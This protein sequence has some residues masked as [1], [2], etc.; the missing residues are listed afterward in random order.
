MVRT[1]EFYKRNYEMEFYEVDEALRVLADLENGIVIENDVRN[2]GSNGLKLCL[3]E[4]KYELFKKLVKPFTFQN[5]NKKNYKYLLDAFS[6]GMVEFI[7]SCPGSIMEQMGRMNVSERYKSELEKREYVPFS[8]VEAA[9]EAIVLYPSLRKE[10][11]DAVYSVNLEKVMKIK[12]K[13]VLARQISGMGHPI[14][15]SRDVI[16]YSELPVLCSALN[17]FSKNIITT[18][19]DTEG[20]YNDGDYVPA[21]GVYITNLI[22]DYGSLD[23]A[24]KLVADTLVESGNAEYQEKSF[25]S[26]GKG[27]IIN[28]PCSRE[29]TVY[30]VNKKMLELVSQFH[31]QDMIYGTLSVDD[32]YNAICR[33]WGFLTP[34]KQAEVCAILDDGYT[35]ENILKI[36]GYFEYISYHYDSEEDKFWISEYY[37]KKHKEYLEEKDLK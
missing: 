22:I 24:N 35:N 37:C 27:L 7:N 12:I 34:D 32:I 14:R 31:K 20:C 36:L 19:N 5:G 30:T 18:A 13:D 9:K 17:L 25:A 4:G 8:D 6:L 33:F 26:E 11:L 16:Y 2:L 29:D 3:A 28:V 1:Y 10:L 15:C 21:S 23:E